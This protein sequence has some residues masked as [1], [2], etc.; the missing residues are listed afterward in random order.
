MEKMTLHRALSELKLIDAKIEKAIADILPTGIHQK[1]KAINNYFTEENFTKAAQSNFDSVMGLIDRKNKIKSLVVIANGA[2]NVTIN[3]QTMTI[4][5]AINLKTSIKLQKKFVETL[6]HRHAQSLVQMGKANEQVQKNLQVILESALGK[7]NVK[8]NKDDY[9]NIATPYL[10]KN[11][12]KV[13][14]PLGIEARIKEIEEKVSGFEVEVD[15]TLSEINATTF[16]V[17]NSDS[18]DDIF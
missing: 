1:G 15:A 18:A 12:V 6:K 2:T 10:E 11:E 5:D 13:F 3:G 4:S 9:D 14:D 16:I 17:L 7:E 8:T